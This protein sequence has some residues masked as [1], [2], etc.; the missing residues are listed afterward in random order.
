MQ[1][2]FVVEYTHELLEALILK[3]CFTLFLLLSFIFSLAACSAEE[4][5]S[6]HTQDTATATISAVGD[7]FLTEA[8][9]ADARH[10]DGSYQF[11]SQFEDVIVAL[12]QADITIGNFEGNFTDSNYNAQEGRYPESLAAELYNVGFDLLQTAN[13]YSIFNGISG[14]ESTKRIIEANGMEALGTYTSPKDREKN[15]VIIREVN[16]IRFAFV[17]FTKGV[18][19]LAIPS[20]SDCSVDLLYKDYTSDYSEINES[21]ITQVLKKAKEASP[22]VIIAALHWGSEDHEEISET[23]EEIA[24]LMAKNGVDVIIGSHSHKIGQVEH[25]S[26]TL[27]SGEKRQCVIAYSLGDFCAV[28]EKECNT[29]MILNLEFTRNGSKTVISDIG[30]TAVSA[31]DRGHMMA[32]RYCV[33]ITEAEIDLYEGNYY[34][35]VSSEVYEAMKSDLERLKKKMEEIPQ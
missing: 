17:A 6:N 32:D 12:S 23:Q 35:H 27:E 20:G 1:A 3:R 19:N 29:S 25:R 13:S 11:A 2:N 31:V 28:G 15:Q 4:K 24:D 14:L 9:L 18:G 26:I 21:Y 22:D 34:D 10:P 33:M 5:S 30:Y 16:G 8:M 7:I